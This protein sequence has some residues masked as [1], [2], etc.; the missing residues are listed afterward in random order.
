MKMASTAI[1]TDSPTKKAAAADLV[2]RSGTPVRIRVVEEADRTLLADFFHHVSR[3]DLRFRFLTSLRALDADRLD[4]LCKVDPPGAI[5][6]LAFCGE[7]L[8]AVATVAGQPDRSQAEIALATRPEWKSHGV[9]WAL[10]DYAI[11]YAKA[12][13][14]RELLSVEKTDNHAAIQMER[15][16][17][18][19]I[20]LTDGDG[21]EVVASRPIRTN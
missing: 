9:S 18:F 2:T 1:R 12:E 13:G 6:F 3:E 19:S 7:D 20:S 11:R 4:V 8:V 10:F 17:G 14:F 5:S 15:E 16:M 21:G